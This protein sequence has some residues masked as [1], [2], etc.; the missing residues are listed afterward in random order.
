MIVARFIAQKASDSDASQED[1]G[2]SAQSW[3]ADSRHTRV[4]L[5]KAIAHTMDS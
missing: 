3:A 4:D 1:A 2:R 5:L